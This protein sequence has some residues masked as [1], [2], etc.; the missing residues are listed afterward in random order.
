MTTL[1]EDCE[2]AMAYHGHLCGGIVL[3]IRMAR[4]GCAHLGIAEPR[5]DRDLVAFVEMARCAADAVYVVTGIT[6]G[7]RRLKLVDQGKMAMTLVETRSGAAVRVRPR[8]GAPRAPQGADP[9]AFFAPYRDEDLLEL[10][11]VRVSIP[12]EDRPGPPTRVAVCARCG[13]QVLDGREVVREGAALCR[14]CAEGAYYAPIP[15][16]SA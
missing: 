15:A 2:R 14:S 13:E 10:Q 16:R 9:V 6:V 12:P 5:A 3:G 4:L 7:K 8:P 11:E 1:Q